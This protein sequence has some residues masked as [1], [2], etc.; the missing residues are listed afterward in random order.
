MRIT[1]CSHRPILVP[2]RLRKPDYQIDPYI[3]CAHC[4]YYC[5]ALNQ[6]ETD[7]TQAIQIYKD[8]YC[9]LRGE[10]EK[11]KPQKIYL[12]YYTD[13]YQPCEVEYRQ[14]RQVL[15]LLLKKGFSASILT[16]SD[17]FLRDVDLLRDM[18]DASISVS[19]AFTDNR[20][21]EKFEA[22]TNDTEVRVEA[23]RKLK[24][25]GVKTSG[26]IC[27]VIPYLT[28]IKG[29]IN[30]LASCTETIWIYGLRID[31]RSDR[32]WQ[33]LSIILK[34]YFPDLSEQIENIIFTK[35]HQFWAQLREELRDLKEN[36]QLDL[37]V[38][39]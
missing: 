11:I 39:L 7:W 30:D 35:D 28:D 2:C 19:V 37:R 21:R 31:E 18:E 38:H 34:K 3:G 6:A 12:G 22:N 36:R 23:L 14:T 20:I 16:K 32:N 29:L 27:P 26:L 33:N 13:P 15:E 4:C 9:Q 10:L 17:L 25:A 1:T 5:Y 8:I 24:E